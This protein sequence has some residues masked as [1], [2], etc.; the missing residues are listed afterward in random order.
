MRLVTLNCWGGR[1]AGPLFDFFSRMRDGVDVFCLQEIFDADQAVLD[2]KHPEFVLVG[3]LFRRIGGILD[4]HE[5]HFARFEDP[6]RMSTALFV[7]KSVPIHDIWE[8]VVYVPEVPNEKGRAIISSRKVH[9]ARLG[10]GTRELLALN[11]H[12]LWV[13][14]PKTDTP[15]RLEQSRCVRAVMDAHEG[16]KVVC[17][18]FNLLPETE[19]VRILDDGHRNLVREYGVPSTRTPLYRH[20]DAPAEPNYADYVIVSRDLEVED[21]RVLPDEVSDHAALC[22][23]FI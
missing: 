12:G 18:D 13:D 23:T 3:D 6:N 11:L 9:C 10:L 16:P 4:G 21:F 22:A 19:S 20:Y 2:R 17:G 14:G 15:E 8:E 7:R 1:A 5:G